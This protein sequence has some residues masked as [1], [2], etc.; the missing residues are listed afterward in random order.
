VRNRRDGDRLRPLGAPG[1]RKLQDVL[2]DRKVPRQERDR[3][4]IVTDAGGRIIWVAGVT[5]AEEGRVRTPDEGVVI[6]TVK[7]GLQ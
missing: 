5:I 2:V 4:P 6:L 3:V 7:K 1:S